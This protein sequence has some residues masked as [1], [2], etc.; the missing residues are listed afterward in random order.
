LG[1]IEGVIHGSY[2]EH[3]LATSRGINTR[4]HLDTLRSTV[5]LVNLLGAEKV[6]IGT[7]AEMAWAWD[8]GIP[9][10]VAMEKEGNVHSHPMLNQWIDYR[11][12]T[13][14]DAIRVTVAIIA[15]HEKYMYDNI[16]TL[17]ILKE[18]N[19]LELE[20]PALYEA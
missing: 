3:P 19:H 11:L 4:D 10:V 13:L 5:V 1:N 18:A 2:E 6:S 20:A 14:D 8:H 17:A 12:D 15:T 7:V 16:E 9:L